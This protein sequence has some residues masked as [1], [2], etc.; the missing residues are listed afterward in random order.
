MPVPFNT[1][2]SAKAREASDQQRGLYKRDFLDD[3]H[4][5]ELAKDSG[6]SLPPYYTRPS[7]SAIKATLRK[8]KIS[9]DTWVEAF[10]WENAEQFEKMNPMWS[11]R[12]LT[13]LILEL[14][15]ERESLKQ[16]MRGAANYRGIQTGVA[17]P[18]DPRYPQGV[19]KAKRKPIAA[20]NQN[21]HANN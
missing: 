15:A 18:K 12:P 14:W 20:L 21:K 6:V 7:D 11:M 5:K 17:K 3:D 9:W 16:N 4:W 1:D 13:G 10:G 19:A 2:S 8:L